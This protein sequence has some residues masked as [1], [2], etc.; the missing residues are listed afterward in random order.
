MRLAKFTVKRGVANKLSIRLGIPR[1][2]SMERKD[3]S[4]RIQK[5]RAKLARKCSPADDTRYKRDATR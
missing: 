4:G 1:A 3:S 2:K 5:R